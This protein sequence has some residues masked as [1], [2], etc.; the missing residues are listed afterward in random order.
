M[1]DMDWFPH[2]FYIAALLVVVGAFCL[3][4]YFIKQAFQS[5]IDAYN[6]LLE[7]RDEEYKVLADR[8]FALKNLAPSD[9]NLAAVYQERRED[10]RQR[11]IERVNG[12][13]LRN[14]HRHGPVDKAQ[15]EMARTAASRASRELQSEISNRRSKATPVAHSN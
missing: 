15:E 10:Q 1:R 11:E 14:P 5:T 9:V 7:R 2:L 6:R 4:D 8:S 13:A 12:G 3:R